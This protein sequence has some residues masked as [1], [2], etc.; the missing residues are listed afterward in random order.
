MLWILDFYFVWYFFQ[1]FLKFK[2]KLISK[3]ITKCHFL[4][5]YIFVPCKSS[6]S[7]YRIYFVQ[8]KDD[9]LMHVLR[10]S[11]SCVLVDNIERLL[12]YGPIGN[13]H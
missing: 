13:I 3:L 7:R 4:E 5:D 1:V 12:D 2:V 11:M 8:K 9:L 6:K 10:S